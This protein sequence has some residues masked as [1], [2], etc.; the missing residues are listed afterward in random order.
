MIDF[1]VY[2]HKWNL[3]AWFIWHEIVPSPKTEIRCGLFDKKNNRIVSL[4]CCWV[5]RRIWL[6]MWMKSFG[7]KYI[8]NDVNHN[9]L[10][11]GKVL[12]EVGFEPTPRELDCDLNAAP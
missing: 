11:R 7:L 3:L 6:L 2:L 12:S 1:N 10:E 5:F 4:L 8:Q 9:N